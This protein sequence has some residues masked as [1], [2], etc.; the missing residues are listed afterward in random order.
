MDGFLGTLKEFFRISFI[1]V[2]WLTV[3]FSFI[4]GALEA[5]R[6]GSGLA[7]GALVAG[8]LLYLF[9]GSRRTI[10]NKR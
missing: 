6:G 10:S 5:N 7:G 2:L 1:V 9:G 3:V 4:G 8:T